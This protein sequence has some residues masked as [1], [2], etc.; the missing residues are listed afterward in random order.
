MGVVSRMM[1]I[2][3]GE[4]EMID[5]LGDNEWDTEATGDDRRSVGNH[6]HCVSV[7]VVLT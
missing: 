4:R 6:R 1:A 5:S 2:F 3:R 7:N